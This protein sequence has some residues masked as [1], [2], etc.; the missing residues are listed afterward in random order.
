[1]KKGFLIFLPIFIISSLVFLLIFALTNDEEIPVEEFE[2]NGTWRVASFHEGEAK[3][4]YDDKFYVFKDGNLTEY[5]NGSIVKESS[6]ELIDYSSLKIKGGQSYY[7]NLI[8]ENI[9]QLYQLKDKKESIINLIRWDQ[10]MSSTSIDTTLIVGKWDVLCHGEG[11]PVSEQLVFTDT[12]LSLY[13]NGGATPTNVSD[14]IIDGDLLK[15]YTIS[16]NVK[17]YKISTDCMIFVEESSGRIWE[18]TKIYQ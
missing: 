15:A 13:R 10:D 1:M 6:Y 14:Y 3:E 12:T 17:I 18:L 7:T 9:L 16:M 8:S 2:L 11:M 5:D 4:L